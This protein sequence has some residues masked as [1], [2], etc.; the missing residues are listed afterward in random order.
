MSENFNYILDSISNRNQ[1]RTFTFKVK[2][3]L[4]ITNTPTYNNPNW[5]PW[6]ELW[7][8]SKLHKISRNGNNLYYLLCSW[9]ETHF[10]KMGSWYINRTFFFDVH[11]PLGKVWTTVCYYL[12][13]NES[14]NIIHITPQMLIA[15]SG[16]M[17]GYDGTYPFEKPG[18]K[19]NE[20]NYAGM[21]IVYEI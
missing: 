5:Y 7:V 18:D 6:C 16:I 4:S 10:G 15:L 11:P 14:Q 9:D 17:T 2:L 8:Q 1:H 21:R 3:Y 19:Y 13:L 20:T 12:F